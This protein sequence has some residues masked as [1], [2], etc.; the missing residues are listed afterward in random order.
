MK[1]YPMTRRDVFRL[2]AAVSATV[3]APRFAISADGRKLAIRTETDINT[4]DPMNIVTANDLDTG[5]AIFSSLI[6]IKPGSDW[7]WQ[8][9]A[10]ESIEQIDSTHIAFTL[11]PG[12]KWTGG[13]GELT[14]EDVKFSFE[15]IADPKN[16]S[17]YQGEW[18][19]LKEVQV[20]GP[21]SGVI[22]LNEPYMPLWLSTL[23]YS[24]GFIMCKKAVEA[25][26]GKFT[27]EPPATSGPYMIQSW[28]PKQKIVLA[29]N[30][31]WNGAPTD[32]DEIELLSI[33]DEKAAEIAFDAHEIAYT[34]V[35]MSSLARLKASPPEGASVL[36]KP[37]VLFIWLGINTEHPQFQD[38]RVRK[39]VQHAVDVDQLLQAAYFGV[40]ERATGIAA[41]GVIGYRERNLIVGRDLDEARRLLAEAGLADG[42]KCT[43]SV[44]NDTDRVSACQIIQAN[45][46]E[47]GIEVEIIPYDSGSY[48]SLGVEADGDTWKDLQLMFL[49]FTSTPDPAYGLQWFVPSQIGQW[50][51]ER[52]R[53]EE[54][55]ELYKKQLI[56]VDAAKRHE[57]LVRMQDLMEESGAYTF[58]TNGVNGSISDASITP[59][60]MPDNRILLSQFASA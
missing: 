13:H 46:A 27:A 36:N 30:P 51:W 47:V 52:W 38:Q 42:F 17:P 53:N 45:L 32:F 31:A 58:I 23:P 5:N 2:A 34:N 22:V 21:L 16:E 57:M 20:T 50:N 14:A 6:K 25:A 9:D 11:R 48:W 39:A 24:S 40:A 54:F 49:R 44:L 55:D 33:G 4:L 1:M 35:S 26:G 41:K 29:R 43:L 59:A 19:T 28:V 37:G 60:T 3:V 18:A 7:E 15:R 10:A 56:E 8:L 12:I